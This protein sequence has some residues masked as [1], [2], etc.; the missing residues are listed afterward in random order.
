MVCKSENRRRSKKTQGRT[1]LNSGGD[2]WQSGYLPSKR[3]CPPPVGRVLSRTSLQ[4]VLSL[5]PC[6]FHEGGPVFKLVED[7]SSVRSS[8]WTHWAQFSPTQPNPSVMQCAPRSPILNTTAYMGWAI[9]SPG[10]QRGRPYEDI[11]VTINIQPNIHTQYMYRDRIWC[12]FWESVY[13]IISS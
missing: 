13:I 2:I 1:G 7:L 6:W 5:F 8:S 3:L 12:D 4:S 9:K 10:E 11:I